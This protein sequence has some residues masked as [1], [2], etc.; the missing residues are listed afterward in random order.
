MLIDIKIN[1]M[2]LI[3]WRCYVLIT[4]HNFSLEWRLCD[5]CLTIIIMHILHELQPHS[6]RHT[7]R[8]KPK[9]ILMLYKFTMSILLLFSLSLSHFHFHVF[10]SLS[11]L[12][13]QFEA[14]FM[15]LLLLFRG[16]EKLRFLYLAILC[17]VD[18]SLIYFNYLF[19]HFHTLAMIIKCI[20]YRVYPHIYF[21]D[22][23]AFVIFTM[24]KLYYA[25]V[26]LSTFW[27]F[28]FMTEW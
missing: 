28:I 4:S 11:C 20:M 17:L 3:K 18:S 5:W 25:C 16:I 26:H 7:N 6:Y 24:L 22:R 8:W 21:Y 12:F 19:Y 14:Y 23:R 10:F 1:K 27:I 2:L 15:V 9:L 13:V